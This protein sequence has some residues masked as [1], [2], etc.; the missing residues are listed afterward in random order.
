MTKSVLFV[1]DELGVL[2]AVMRR[3]RKE[4]FQLRTAT[5]AEEAWGILSRSPIDLVVSDNNMPGMSGLDFL[6]MVA[7][8]FPSCIRIML[9]GKP[10]LDAAMNAINSGEVYRFLTKPYDSEALAALIREALEQRDKSGATPHAHRQ[11]EQGGVKEQPNDHTDKADQIGMH[12][13]SL[14]ANE[15]KALNGSEPAPRL[16]MDFLKNV[17]K[18]GHKVR[19]QQYEVESVI[20]QGAMG[21]VLK[22]HDP[23]LDRDVALKLLAPGWEDV[24]VAHQRF[25]QEARFAAAIRHENVVTIFAVSDVEGVPFLV[26]EYVPGKSLQD[27]LDDGEKFAVAEVIRIGRQVALGLAA[28]HALRLI[29]RDIKPGNILLERGTQRVRITDFGLARA[30]DGNTKLSQ[31]GTLLGTPQYMSPEQVDGKPLT[32]SSDLFSLGS[33]LYTLCAGQIPFM[34]ASLSRLLHAIAEETPPPLQSLNPEVPEWLAQLIAKL[35]AKKP[36]D[37]YPTAGA[38]AECLVRRNC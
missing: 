1:D 5:S 10:S 15:M 19:I 11:P 28:A 2:Q 4:P 22:A 31:T 21:I 12:A 35:H 38:V 36:A 37:R 17:G 27:C 33:V 23:G 8:E 20:G 25:A 32:P 6:A 18:P 16:T 14:P 13:S 34:S 29:H 9:T 26:M 24:S 7:K 30:L 3:M